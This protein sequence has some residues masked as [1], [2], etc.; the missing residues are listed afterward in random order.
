MRA[1]RDGPRRV[2]A[3]VGIVAVVSAIAA[4][5]LVTPPAVSA[6]LPSLTYAGAVTEFDS[7]VYKSVRVF[8]PQGTRLVG[9]GFSLI[10]AEGAVVL[11]DFIP[12]VTSLLVG[13]G[14]IVG[15]G[16]PAD[17]T[18]DGWGILATAVCAAGLANYS[19]RSSTSEFRFGSFRSATVHCL[20]GSIIGAGASLSQGFGQVSI[21]RMTIAPSLGSASVDATTEVAGF[22]GRWSV[23]SYAI[24]ADPLPGLTAETDRTRDT[25]L[26][27]TN[28][29]FCAAGKAP[30]G[31][32]W[33]L[34]DSGFSIDTYITRLAVGTT[35]FPNVSVSAVAAD[36]PRN[37]PWTLTMQAICAD[38]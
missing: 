23:T 31:G 32:G 13:A 25:N 9:G 24:C 1:R 37:F 28:S 21:K 11:D 29:L 34:P 10:G 38:V 30:I 26:R 22:D 14:E 4:A 6:S 12:S 15:L 3:A 33:D 36:P 5:V 17:G 20:S 35:T 19:I 18:P 27:R 8:C 7:T 2:S 16:E